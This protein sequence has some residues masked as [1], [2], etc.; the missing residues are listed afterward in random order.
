MTERLIDLD[1]RAVAGGDAADLA[2]SLSRP[3]LV[4]GQN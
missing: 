4:V 1:G 3:S 2:K